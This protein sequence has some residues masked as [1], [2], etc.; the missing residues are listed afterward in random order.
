MVAFTGANVCQLLPQ[1]RFACHFLY[2][3]E[4]VMAGKV[5]AAIAVL[6]GGFLWEPGDFCLFTFFSFLFVFVAGLVGVK[7]IS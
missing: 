4:S 6:V 1:I 2:S 5:R 7:R 3:Q